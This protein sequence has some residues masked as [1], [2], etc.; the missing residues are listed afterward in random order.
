MQRW[1]QG[2][3]LLLQGTA[4]RFP[5]VRLSRTCPKEWAHWEHP[6]TCKKWGKHPLSLQRS[7][8]PP[9]NGW[10]LSPCTAEPLGEGT[11]LPHCMCHRAARFCQVYPT[12]AVLHS[13]AP[14]CCFP[15]LPGFC[16][17]KKLAVIKFLKVLGTKK[18]GR[19]GKKRRKFSYLWRS[20]TLHRNAERGVV[21]L[22]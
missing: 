14:A 15:D 3:I 22:K 12:R 7:D 20:F 16:H 1:G 19:R 13:H 21:P 17:S 2:T 4:R 6:P 9:S 8:P 10:R 18:S 11:L 5:A